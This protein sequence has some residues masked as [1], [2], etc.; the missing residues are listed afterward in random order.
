MYLMDNAA[1]LSLLP[2]LM[3]TGMGFGALTG[4]AATMTMKHL[5]KTNLVK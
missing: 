5:K 3:I 4:V 2:W 1:L